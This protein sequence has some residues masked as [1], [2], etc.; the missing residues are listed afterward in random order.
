MA[1]IELES[2]SV[3][4]DSRGSTFATEHQNK[5]MSRKGQRGTEREREGE[6][7]LSNT[8]RTAL[9]N[10]MHRPVLVFTLVRP[11][12]EKTIFGAVTTKRLQLERTRLARKTRKCER[13]LLWALPFRCPYKCE[14]TKNK[15]NKQMPTA[16]HHSRASIKIYRTRKYLHESTEDKSQKRNLLIEGT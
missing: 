16:Q 11:R 15:G 5:W 7:F 1:A 10:N 12:C 8:E 3:W 6:K 13:I 2:A 9:Y 4:M 14:E